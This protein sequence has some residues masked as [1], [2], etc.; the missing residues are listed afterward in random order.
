MISQLDQQ[1]A[2]LDRQRAGLPSEEVPSTSQPR[3][4]TL[5]A[6]VAFAAAW[7]KLVERSVAD[8][9]QLAQACRRAEEQF[10]E[11]QV[12]QSTALDGNAAAVDRW[13]AAAARWDEIFTIPAAI[14]SS[15]WAVA[16]AAMGVLGWVLARRTAA[17]VRPDADRL[18]TSAGQLQRWFTL[19]AVTISAAD[20]ETATVRRRRPRWLVLPA[21]FV[22][23]VAVFCLVATTI[24]NPSWI[25]DL[26]AR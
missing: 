24:Q 10:D 20:E 19:P 15:L 4:T 5:A 21:Q 2:D 7:Q 6:D 13:I 8:Y 25:G 26:L 14:G 1:I 3:A 16:C 11:T 17:R 9:D 12:A 22:M 23:A 18:I